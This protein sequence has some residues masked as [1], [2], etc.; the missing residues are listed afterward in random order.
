VS[1]EELPGSG[2]AGDEQTARVEV[3]LTEGNCQ[4]V[5]VRI[6]G[7]LTEDPIAPSGGGKTH[8]RTD[9]RLRQIG[10]RERDEYYFP[11]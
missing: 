5:A 2:I 1:R 9:L 8:G 6:A 7:D 11:G 3:G 4:W 10:E